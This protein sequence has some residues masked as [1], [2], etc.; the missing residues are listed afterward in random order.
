MTVALDARAVEP[1]M[2]P[3]VVRFA[4]LLLESKAFGCAHQHFEVDGA[5]SSDI[6][7]DAP[8][9]NAD[10]TVLHFLW[11]CLGAHRVAGAF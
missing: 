7:A 4:S 2:Q 3:D 8:V 6:D 5:Q 9:M 10:W 11:F 1:V